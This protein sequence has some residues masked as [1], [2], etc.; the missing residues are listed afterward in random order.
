MRYVVILLLVLGLVGCGLPLRPD[1]ARPAAVSTGPV[2]GM[3]RDNVCALMNRNVLTG[4]EIDPATGEARPI[5]MKSLYST[6][7]MASGAESYLVDFFITGIVKTEDA[8]GGGRMMSA[9]SLTPMI[10]KDNILVGMGNDA[11]AALGLKR[12]DEK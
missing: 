3:T 6:E 4:Y 9:G 10:F 2:L 1:M 11:F 8:P 7:I 12:S 5:E